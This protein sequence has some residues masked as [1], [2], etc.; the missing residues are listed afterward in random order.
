MFESLPRW[1]EIGTDGIAFHETDFACQAPPTQ[2]HYCD[3]AGQG[4]LSHNPQIHGE[5][6][7]DLWK[8]LHTTKKCEI[9]RQIFVDVTDRH[10]AKLGMSYD[11]ATD[12]FSEKK[13]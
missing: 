13:A 11:E 3:C 12:T 9:R 2:V 7:L 10:D 4:K 8:S 1:L 5:D 6:T